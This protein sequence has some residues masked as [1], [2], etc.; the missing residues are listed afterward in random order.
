MVLYSFTFYNILRNKQAKKMKFN[1]CV[2]S[3]VLGIYVRV[4]FCVSGP[5]GAVWS[6]DSHWANQSWLH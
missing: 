3:L 2:G 1:Q 6:P 4:W 5:E